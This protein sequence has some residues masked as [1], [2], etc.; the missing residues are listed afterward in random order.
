MARP[1]RTTDGPAPFCPVKATLDLLGRKWTLLLIMELMGGVRRFNKLSHAL[2]GVNSRTLRER[3]R[4][5]ERE[6]LV[7]RRVVSAIPPWVEYS[8]TP[9]GRALFKAMD[10]LSQWGRRWMKPPRSAV[11]TGG[12]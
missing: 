10:D 9:K 3:L 11:R 7:S 8:L 4:I 12:R 5:M 2:A 6:N 1:K